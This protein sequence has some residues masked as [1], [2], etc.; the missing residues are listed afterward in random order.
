MIR[1]DRMNSKQY[2]FV[3]SMDPENM[4]NE[5]NNIPPFVFDYFTQKEIS[6]FINE[7]LEKTCEHV[8]GYNGTYFD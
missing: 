3:G 4:I 1:A 2:S 5:N 7:T 6:H 8:F